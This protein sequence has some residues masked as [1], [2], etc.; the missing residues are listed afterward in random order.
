MW[1]FEIYQLNKDTTPFKKAPSEALPLK[2]M[3]AF[4]AKASNDNLTFLSSCPIFVHPLLL[5][6]LNSVVWLSLNHF[7]GFLFSTHNGERTKGRYLLNFSYIY[8]YIYANLHTCT[9]FRLWEKKHKSN[10]TETVICA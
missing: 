4:N 5:F 10:S 7:L 3:D 2:F 8:I 9:F 6:G 1:M